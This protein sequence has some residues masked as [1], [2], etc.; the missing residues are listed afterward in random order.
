MNVL[1]HHEHHTELDLVSTEAKQQTLTAYKFCDSL[2]SIFWLNYPSYSFQ[3]YTSPSP[4]FS[5]AVVP[6]S[7]VQ[8]VA[9]LLFQLFRQFLQ[10]EGCLLIRTCAFG[11]G[12]AHIGVVKL[13]IWNCWEDHHLFLLS[14]HISARH[15]PL[16][17]TTAW[18]VFMVFFCAIKVS[19]CTLSE[20]W[21]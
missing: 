14:F 4:T 21:L 8:G 15:V 20:A 7:D 16:M 2:C 9:V 10:S 3:L 6:S 13:P 11:L 5:R 18:P 1:S 17:S 12:E 19:G